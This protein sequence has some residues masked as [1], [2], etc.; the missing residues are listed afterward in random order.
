MRCVA[1]LPLLLFPLAAGQY[2]YVFY[3]GDEA[4]YEDFNQTDPERVE[5]EVNEEDYGGYYDYDYTKDRNAEDEVEEYSEGEAPAEEEDYEENE[6]A[7]EREDNREYNNEDDEYVEGGKREEEDYSEREEDDGEDGDYEGGE[8]YEDDYEEEESTDE[9]TEQL[10]RNYEILSEFYQK[11]FVDLRIL[12]ESC[13]GEVR[14]APTINHGSVAQY[15]LV[16]FAVKICNLK[17]IITELLI[18][19]KHTD[20]ILMFRRTMFCFQGNTTRGQFTNARY[21]ILFF[22]K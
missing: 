15:L 4:E 14:P 12:D 2:K 19:I 6:D 16:G 1:F 9:D 7:Q 17:R 21:R 5:V 8:E 13:D 22:E 20:A 18:V 10:Y 11:H 3:D